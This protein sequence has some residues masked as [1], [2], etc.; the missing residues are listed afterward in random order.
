[1]IDGLRPYPETKATGLP[2][3]PT[4]PAHWE[5]LP[6]K[7]IAVSW[8]DGP[9]GS[10]LKSSH[11]APL[12][13]RV[14][15][16][17]NI[18]QGCFQG[19]DAAF[20]SEDHQRSLGDH[21]VIA[22][23]LIVAGLGDENHPT[24]RAC[25]APENIGPAIVKADCFRFRLRQDRVVPAFAA[26]YMTATAAE[27]S[28]PLA[29]GATRQRVNLRATATRAIVLPLLPEQRMIVRFLDAHGAL[30]ARLIRAKQRIIKLLE[31]QKQAIIHRAVTRGLDPNVP[32]QTLR[33]S[34]TRRRTRALGGYG[35]QAD[36]HIV[37]RRAIWIRIEVV[38][39]RQS[40]DS[41]YSTPKHRTRTFQKYRCRLHP[42]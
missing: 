23:D 18:G 35:P 38:A 33:H 8:C 2:W 32:P 4:I 22:D 21:S 42:R 9:F 19:A 28:A 20:V 16:L 7:R 29:T 17:Q 31:E 13:V 5:V 12:G 30:T 34:L 15:Q 24:G 39:L 26:L 40:R 27:A 41:R 3:L 11:Y 1:M 36:S 6:L 25:V 14:I 37:V 10:G